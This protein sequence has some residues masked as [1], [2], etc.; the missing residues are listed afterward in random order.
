[1]KVECRCYTCGC[2]CEP[3]ELDYVPLLPRDLR[4]PK[5]GCVYDG[6]TG[7]LKEEGKI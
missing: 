2:E 3:I 7:D 5:C 6:D 4:C 1:M